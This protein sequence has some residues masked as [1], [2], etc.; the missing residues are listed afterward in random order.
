MLICCEIF[1][2][3]IGS[4]VGAEKSREIRKIVSFWEV[5]KTFAGPNFTIH[6]N[7]L[8]IFSSSKCLKSVLS[9][10]SSQKKPLDFECCINKIFCFFHK[11]SVV[12]AEI[13]GYRGTQKKFFRKVHELV[14]KTSRFVSGSAFADLV[15]LMMQKV[16]FSCFFGKI[17][18]KFD[19]I[20]SF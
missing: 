2:K 7:N 14:F 8:R 3:K 9:I 6:L 12:G 13:F 15:I 18:V 4:R 5:T 17:F 10:R 20:G 19:L 1:Q 16:T 11:S